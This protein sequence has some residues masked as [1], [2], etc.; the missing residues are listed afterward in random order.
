MTPEFD[1]LRHN[2]LLIDTNLLL[3]YIAGTIDRSFVAK[4]KR[5]AA[6]VAEDFDTL[7]TAM[8]RF[9]HF[10]TT[11]NILTEVSNL[12][13]SLA[14]ERR[15][16]YIAIFQRITEVFREELPTSGITSR[17]PEF[18]RLGLTDAGILGLSGGPVLVLT[19]DLNLYLAL[20]QRNVAVMNFNH[21]RLGAWTSAH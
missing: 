3:L 10:L 9:P 6:F 8:E 21:I 12:T 19:D 1:P 13:D 4:F 17:V 11:S 14:G 20:E 5:T 2:T 16:R 7:R 18:A 15:S